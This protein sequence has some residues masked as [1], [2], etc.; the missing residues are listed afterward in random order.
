MVP[1][2]WMYSLLCSVSEGT[3]IMLR[4][5]LAPIRRTTYIKS[6]VTYEEEETDEVGGEPGKVG[7]VLEVE[8]VEHHA[9]AD[10]E[11]ALNVE[12]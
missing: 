9:E 7:E 8:E 10:R 6:R 5:M 1:Y 2:F 4:A 12:S 3:F 11:V